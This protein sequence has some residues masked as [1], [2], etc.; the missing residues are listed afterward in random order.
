MEKVREE[1]RRI[2]DEVNKELSE[3]MQRRKEEEE[4]EQRKRDELI[5]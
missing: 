5:R 2:R 1:K 3:A 4:V